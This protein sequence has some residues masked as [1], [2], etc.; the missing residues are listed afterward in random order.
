M[1]YQSFNFATFG[2]LQIAWFGFGFVTKAS[3][4]ASNLKVVKAS[5]SKI[6]KVSA[7]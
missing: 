5:A 1:V 2:S 3:A 4:S 6:E 7:S